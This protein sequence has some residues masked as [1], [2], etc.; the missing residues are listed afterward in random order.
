M[1]LFVFF[2][3]DASLISLLAVWMVKA[4]N[5]GSLERNQLIGIR[6]K[7]TLASDE[8]WDVAHKAAIPYADHGVDA[9]VV[10]NI[11]AIQEVADALR[12]A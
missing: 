3:I 1:I 10:D 7:A 9:V 5:E 12:A 8:A 2:L 4:A 11:D 6:T